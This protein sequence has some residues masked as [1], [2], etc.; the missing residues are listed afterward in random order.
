[1]E[2][3][4]ESPEK[5]TQRKQVKPPKDVIVKKSLFGRLFSTTP[6]PQPQAKLEPQK[7]SWLLSKVKST[8]GIKTEE[9]RRQERKNRLKAMNEQAEKQESDES[10]QA[11]LGLETVQAKSTKNV[12]N[13]KF[14]TKSTL[15]LNVV[16][17]VPKLQLAKKETKKEES[18]VSLSEEDPQK[19]KS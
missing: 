4:I 13:Y 18:S 5:E 11:L 2:K 6:K 8:L 1:M 10:F 17:K 12:F 9:E 3:K 14:L 19:P 15:R 7:P 16:G